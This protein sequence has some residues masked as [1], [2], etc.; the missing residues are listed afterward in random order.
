MPGKIL[1][2]IDDEEN[3]Y[4][5]LANFLNLCHECSRKVLDI[6]EIAEIG[7][8]SVPAAGIID[9][10]HAKCYGTHVPILIE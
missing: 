9:H 6:T 4:P 10:I 3:D 8:T 7:L 1:S 5:E 2:V